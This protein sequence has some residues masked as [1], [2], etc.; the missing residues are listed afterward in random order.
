MKITRRSFL[1][2]TLCLG[3]ALALPGRLANASSKAADQGTPGYAKLEDRGQLAPRIE[4]A[5]AIFEECRLCPREC[6]VNR[7][8]GQS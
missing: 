3:G 6:G 8:A 1:K 7:L 2:G 4:Q 5:R